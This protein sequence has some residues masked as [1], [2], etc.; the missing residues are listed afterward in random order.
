M[1]QLVAFLLFLFL[2]VAGWNQSFKEQYER[3][4]GHKGRVAAEASPTPEQ[5]QPM[6]RVVMPTPVNIAPPDNGW[7]FQKTVLDRKK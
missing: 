1:V 3:I 5:E 6:A 7:R 2:I 4:T